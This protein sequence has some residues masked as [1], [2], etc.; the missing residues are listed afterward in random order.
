MEKR[1]L[2]CADEE[3]LRNPALLGLEEES[4]SCVA[5]MEC[6]SDAESCRRAARRASVEEIWVVSCDDMEPVNVAAGIKADNPF[7][8]VLLAVGEN[9]GSLSSRATCAS[10]DGTLSAEAFVE[11]FY[12]A[13]QASCA[14]GE[15]A[16]A[17]DRA[18]VARE[19]STKQT[20]EG[21]GDDFADKASDSRRLSQASR[22]KSGT[23][24][25]VVGASG[26]CGKGTIAS[27]MST[28]C[29]R[30]GLLTLA[31]DADLQFGDMHRM[32]GVQEPFR[33][34]DVVSDPSRMT[35]LYEDAKAT[36]KPSLLAAPLKL[37]SSE[38]IAAELPDIVE[39]ARGDYDV[40]IVCAGS[41]WE[42]IHAQVIE[43]SDAVAFLMDARPSS[44]SATIH[45]VELCSRMGLAT[46]GFTYAV[47]RHAKESLLSAVDASCS[48]KGAAAVE[49]AEGGRDVEELLGAGFPDEFIASRNSLTNDT[50][51]LLC[52]LLSADQAAKVEQFACSLG[53]RRRL[54]G[55]GDRR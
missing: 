35:R 13:K 1:V 11:R 19:Q 55:R 42:E 12:E 51:A 21:L 43:S 6:R 8:K 52:R 14:S 10:I 33:I 41:F 2:L 54:F 31:I 7:K 40:V 17:T 5:L 28:L 27:L 29:A 32:F 30:S 4:F 53:K 16:T 46:S 23:V 9:S 37:E 15:V 44:L 38:A 22:K 24:I 26:G 47:N 18:F 34:D 48:L 49:L 25:C 50:A 45:A 20:G 39:A 36:G 3:S